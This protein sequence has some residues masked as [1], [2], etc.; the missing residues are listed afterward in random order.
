MQQIYFPN[1]ADIV[2]AVSAYDATSDVLYLGLRTVFAI[3]DADGDNDPGVNP[4]N[5]DGTNITEQPGIGPQEAYNFF[6]DTN[7]DGVPDITIEIANNDVNVFPPAGATSLSFN[8][9]DLEVSVAGLGLPPVYCYAAF[10]GFTFDGLAEDQTTQLCC[11]GPTPAILVEL[12]CPTNMCPGGTEN[13]T[14]TVTNTGNTPLSGVTLTIPL[15]ANLNFTSFVDEDAWDNCAEAAGTIT[16]TESNLPFF[17]VRVVTFSVTA[18]PDC[19]GTN[20]VPATAVGAF[21]QP[22]CFEET[23]VQS[24]TG[25]DITCTSP[26]CEITGDNVI[27]QGETTQ[28]CASA[29]QASYSWTGPGGFTANTQCITVGVAGEYCVTVTDVNGCISNCCRTLTVN[30]PPPCSVTG[31]NV[32]CQGETTQFCAP[33]G[34]ASYAWTGPGG[35]TANTQCIT[36][37]VAGEYCVTITDANGC[38]SN[39]CRTL[40]VNPPPPCDIA[41]KD[42]AICQGESAEFCAPA[43]MA[44]YAWTGPGGFTA[45]TRCIKI[46]VAGEYCVTITDI[47]GC[48]SSCCH[49]LTV[50]PPPP[51]NVTGDNTICQGQ[52]TQ[53][54]APAGMASYA[55]TGPGGFTANTQCVTVGVA[56]QYC[57]TITDNNGCQSNCC[58]TLT[59]S[60]PPPCNVTGDNTI[61][62]GQTTQFCAPAGMASYAWTGPGGF[63]AT[64]QCVTV[65]VAG[66]YCVTITDNNGCSTNCCQTLIVSPP[67]PCNV[68]GDNTICQGQTTQFCAPAGMV[69]YAWTG[70]G[71]FTANTQC[72]TVGVA[73]QYC[74]TITDNNGC[75]SNCC[76][77]LIVSPPPPCNVTGDNT[78]CQ[79]ETT[80]FCAPAGMASYA[81]TG[82]GGFTANTQC[83]TIGTAGEY[84][85]TITDKNGCVSNCCRTL[86]VNPPPPCNVTGDDEICPGETTEFCAPAGMAS[87]SWTG[88]G[89][90]TATTRCITVSVAGQYCVTLTDNNGCVSDCDFEG[91]GGGCLT[92]TVNPLPVCTITT[93]STTICE[94]E[95]AEFCGPGGM[96]SYAWTG[97][98]GFI[99]TT[100][101][102]TIGVAG[103]YCLTVTD[104]NGCENSCC[105]ELTVVVCEPAC[106]RTVGFWSQQCQCA[107]GEGGNV[108]YSC[109]EMDAITDCIVSYSDYF[110]AAW[111]DNFDGFCA[112]LNP[113]RPMRQEKQAKRQFAG[114]LANVCAGELEIPANNG[115]IVSLPPETP[116]SCGAFDATNIG[117]LIEEIDALLIALENGDPNPGGSYNDIIACA[118]GINNGIGIPSGDCGEGSAQADPADEGMV[119]LGTMVDG[120]AEL[121]RFEEPT[122]NPFRDRTRMAYAVPGNAAM[123]VEVSIYN[124]S[125]Q[126]VRTLVSG[127]KTAGGYEAIW[128]GRRDDGQDVPAGVYFYRLAV[129]GQTHVSRVVLMR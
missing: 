50:N 91:P 73:G 20:T 68:T 97:P 44:S 79:G 103:D 6:I 71:G 126:R 95:T 111:G 21:G 65:G 116:I 51:C 8:G 1:G 74:V 88:P 82:P 124:I 115:N 98:G 24:T 38:V 117:E 108:K 72:V 122:P 107:E 75:T 100:Q 119:D 53:F 47:N 120:A 85:V 83:I 60:P 23:G 55:W 76:Q 29:G 45:N 96:A 36:I 7:C 9:T 86:T 32:I 127:T 15:P 92:L 67:P 5:C 17:G 37:G 106:P 31:D 104:A 77:T 78:I 11:P 80:Q 49:T 93:D 121:Q 123:Q 39:C 109:S 66:E 125:G 112:T 12:D 70:P 110:N 33:A 102:I 18:K 35:F 99:A 64:T 62:Q 28:F 48:V 128:D 94:G 90:F 118:D 22:G 4:A 54:C 14:A 113:P 81:W 114:L 63:T 56:G 40:T 52:T 57:V 129:G 27:C 105:Q 84:C 41:T 59:V 87:Y 2:T 30:P 42:D 10:A 26:L 43:G 34:M 3:G 89:G 46:S 69:S 58:Q 13:I 16:C 101:C 25:C 61:C 19:D